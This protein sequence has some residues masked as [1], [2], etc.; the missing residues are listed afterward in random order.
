MA[1]R[2]YFKKTLTSFAVFF[3]FLCGATDRAM[4]TDFT[5]WASVPQEFVGG[6]QDAGKLLLESGAFRGPESQPWKWVG[7]FTESPAR[8]LEIQ[9]NV[10]ITRLATDFGWFGQSWS[11]W[12]DPTYGDSGFEAGIGLAIDH[13]NQS[14]Y[15]VQFSQ[16]YQSVALVRYPLGGYVRV[17]PCTIEKDKPLLVEVNR[18]GR[19]IRVRVDGKEL[20]QYLDPLPLLPAGQVGL[21][22]SSRGAVQFEK[23][24]LK[25][26]PPVAEK[27]QPVLPMTSHK[28]NFSSRKWLG[29]QPWVFDGD[30]PILMLPIQYKQN[31]T[32]Y[33]QV[34]NSVKLQP[35][36]KPM[37]MWNAHW[38]IAGQGAWKEGGSK[39]TEPQVQ[40][41]GTTLRADWQAKHY[42]NRFQTKTTL[43]IG[44]DNKRGTYTYDMDSQLEIL[45]GAPFRLDAFPLEHHAPLDPFNWK[46]LVFR[47]SKDELLHR[48]V[49]PI[50]PGPTYNIAGQNG[51]RMWYGRHSEPMRVAP[52]VEY[53]IEPTQ[54]PTP[55]DPKLKIPRQI[56]TAVCAAFYDTGIAY[57]A[58]VLPAGSTVRTRYRYT[59]YPAEEAERV[60]R[61]SKLLES[62]RLDPNHHYIWADAWP[63][64]TFA[65]AKAMSEPWWDAH[66]PF[67]AAHNQ[68]PTYKWAKNTGTGSGFALQLPPRSFGQSDLPLPKPLA[69]G[70]YMLRGLCK[71]DR[72]IGPGGRVELTAYAKDNRKLA[73]FTH[74][75]GNG[76]FD[77]KPYG[78][79]F[80]L[81]EDATRLNVAFGNAGTGDFYIGESRF[82]EWRADSPLPPDVAKQ[83]QSQPAKYDPS[84]KGAVFDARLTEG[85][86]HYIFNHAGQEFDL[87]ELCNLTWEKVD[88]RTGLRFR[89]QAEGR[90]PDFARGGGLE[91]FFFALD[92]YQQG[93]TK[94]FA[95]SGSHGS[96]QRDYK[97]L[98][99]ATWIRPAAEMTKNQPIAD[100]LGFGSRRVRLHLLGEKAPY[101]FGVRF[102]EGGE[103]IWSGDKATMNADR[104]YLVAMTA[105]AKG[106]NQWDIKLYVDGKQ[107]QH[108]V[109]KNVP[110]PLKCHA[111]IILGTELHYMHTNYY[112][113][114]IGRTLIFDRALPD[115]EIRE[116]M[117]LP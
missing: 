109:A 8:D 42:A 14:G 99:L 28:P 43:T 89:Q 4:A 12:P 65:K 18:R 38:D 55:H 73:E 15:R 112:H 21:L 92:A 81:P 105:E 84:P 29:N 9:A 86:G 11:V 58:E 10:R 41:G 114:L 111:S 23:V 93:K 2:T 113:G 74:Y 102:T 22:T 27:D 35:G 64:L 79:V 57:D 75:L 71:A 52:A 68:R 3:T 30:E 95:I 32:Y 98:T 107:V 116:L 104:W 37:L 106:E 117:K 50:D 34:I 66:M 83:P 36:L 24:E 63:R 47:K 20:I 76:D 80:T 39:S 5:K 19:E 94:T 72:V 101:Q 91:F 40:G 60:F 61:S 110:N 67:M 90:K 48:P 77:W 1:I 87:L 88:G 108:A 115:N 45:P 7:W 33:V 54:R 26:L 100:I 51:L 13:K 96:P 49:F 97:A 25:A 70:R 44:F 17:A 6:K 56:N 78:I 69:A 16:K 85:K 59:G 103:L 82:E 46:Y 31:D 62:P 53:A